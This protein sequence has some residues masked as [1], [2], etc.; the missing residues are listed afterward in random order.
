M[1]SDTAIA[2]AI[3]ATPTTRKA[4]KREAVPWLSPIGVDTDI[5]IAQEPAPVPTPALK[6]IKPRKPYTP[7]APRPLPNPVIPDNPAPEPVG[8]PAPIVPGYNAQEQ[9]TPSTQAPTIPTPKP[10]QYPYKTP[11]E[12]Q[13]EYSV[14][15]WG[16]GNGL[17]YP[18]DFKANVEF[19]IKVINICSVRGPSQDAMIRRVVADPCCFID[20][21]CCTKDPRRNPDVLPFILYDFQRTAVMDIVDAIDGGTDLLIDKSRDMGASWLVLY[22]FL[23]YWL[24]K[25]G[26]DFRVGSRKEDFVDQPK[27]IDTLF[28]KL[29]FT[30]DNLPLWLLPQGFDMKKHSTYMKLYNPMFGNSIVGESANNNFGSGGRSKAVLL[31]E[32]SKWDASIAESAWTST[33]DVAKCRL[34]VSTPC[35]SGNKFAQLALGTGEEKIKRLSLHWT[36]HPNKAKYAYYLDGSKQRIPLPSPAEAFKAWSKL[37]LRVRSPWY[38]AEAERRSASDLAQ[39]VDIDYLRSGS[40]FFDI[41][42]LKQQRIWTH[43]K[44][45]SPLSPIPYGKYIKLRLLEVNGQIHARED[46]EGSWLRVYEIPERGCQYAI[47]ADTAEGLTKNDESFCVVRNRYSFHVAAVFNGI[48]DPEEFS[49]KIWLVH[50]YFNNAITAP[51]NNNHGH[52]TCL[53]FD[54]L[55]GNL[56]YAKRDTANGVQVN[57]LKK[58]WSTDS[59]TRPLMLDRLATDIKKLFFEIRDEEIIRQCFTFV[60]NGEKNGKPE[61]DGMLHDD[62]VIALAICGQVIEEHPYKAE[63]DTRSRQYAAINEARLQRRNAGISFC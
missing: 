27:V 48:I 4:R 34:P 5:P 12:V 54:E 62:G 7:R 56:Y 58:G 13:A 59:R 19:R 15:D 60:R 6:A 32:F 43:D 44:S 50:K 33:A 17:P 49:Y 20:L 53:K 16:W 57:V 24:F 37:G 42:A 8:P 10:G 21:F 30:L 41:Q 14:Q 31:D 36:L 3:E 1:G 46:A 47:G 26:S 9:A 38:D 11:R 28:E 29:R 51:E 23:W 2:E 39:E 52:T 25:P 63:K 45:H 22:V 55:G 61:A 35:G 40:P 18:T